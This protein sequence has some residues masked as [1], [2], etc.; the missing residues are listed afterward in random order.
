MNN[1]DYLIVGAGII[2]MTIAWELKRNDPKAK[3]LIIEK[4]DDAGRHSSGRNSGV[5]HSGFYYTAD[6]LKAKFTAKGNSSMKSFCKEN[7]IKVNSCQ[8]VVV[9]KDE[10]EVKVLHQLFERGKSNG[11]DVRIINSEELAQIDPNAKTTQIA[12]HSPST[13]TVDPLEVCLGLKKKLCEM[14]VE[15]SFG[16]KYIA[17]KNGVIKTSKG[18]FETKYFINAAGLYADK[19]AHEWGFGKKYTIIPFKGI[20]LKYT[21]QEPV[22]RTNI[23]PVPNLKN[24]F[25]GVHFTVTHDGHFKIGPTA[26]PAFW[27]ENYSWSE[28][29]SLNEFFSILYYEAKLFMTNAFRFRDLAF[30]EMKK[31]SKIHFVDLAR[32]L[33]KKMDAKGF[34]DWGRPGIRAQLLNTETSELVQDFVIEGDAQSLHI[35]NAVSPA[36]TCSFPFA[37]YIRNIVESKVR[38]R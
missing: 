20:Y 23:Y 24:P 11:V 15:F 19:I 17:R 38:A 27:R 8:K 9:A 35:L 3:I 1:S 18:L 31:Y 10:S 36:F 13:A 26:I 2:G 33:V 34:T 37:E 6:S 28:N 22:V 29:F 25:L 4:E 30:E 16:T 12:L 7:G 32:A 14:G 5:L 21:G